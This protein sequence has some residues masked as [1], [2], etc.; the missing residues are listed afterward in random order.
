MLFLLFCFITYQSVDWLLLSNLSS[1]D[2][3][4]KYCYNCN[5]QQNVND[6]TCAVCKKSEAQKMTSIN[7]I[8]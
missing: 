3:S 6:S 5:N 8:K 4:E 2:D 7:A 1:P